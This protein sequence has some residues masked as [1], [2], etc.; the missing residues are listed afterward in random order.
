MTGWE[1]API[2]REM[3]IRTAVVTRGREGAVAESDEGSW[4]SLAPRVRAV[5][6]V[7]SGDAFLAGVVHSLSRGGSMEEA[8][9]LGGVGGRAAGLPPGPAPCPPPGRE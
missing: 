5:S 8:L 9:R 2:L 3:T 4:R 1:A 6:A 7:G